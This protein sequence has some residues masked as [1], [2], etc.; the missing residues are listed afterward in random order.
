LR[1]GR[2]AGRIAEEVLQ[3]LTTIAG[4]NVRVSLEIQA[5][6]PQGISEALQRV[7]DENCR[8]LKFRAQGFE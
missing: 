4:T 8:P 7:L 6:V 1:V 5:D 3:H 2:D